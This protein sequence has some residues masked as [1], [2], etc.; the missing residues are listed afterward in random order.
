MADRFLYIP[1]LGFCMVA[2]YCGALILGWRTV[3]R[4]SASY[5]VLT[6]ITCMVILTVVRTFYW[7]N[8]A[9]LWFRTLHTNPM[10]Y[11]AYGSIAQILEHQ[12]KIDDAIAAVKNGLMLKPNDHRLLGSLAIL[13]MRK[14]EYKQALYYFT[15]SLKCE[16]RDYKP[17]ANM[18]I[19]YS[20]MGKVDEAVYS[21]NRAIELNPSNI[22]LHFY[23]AEYCFKQGQ[24]QPALDEY[25]AIL[26]LDPNNIDALTALASLYFD[27]LED[28]QP[29]APLYKRIMELQ[30]DNIEAYKRYITCN[31]K[32]LIQRE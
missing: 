2:G 19:M 20:E 8:S 21:I 14:K 11:R 16:P 18:F 23:K 32:L 10:S 31:D 13:Y 5:A 15:Q 28:Y 9:R 4:R 24:I 6:V 29:A 27:V 7:H 25:A 17:Y 1:S 26:R 12:G 3:Y 22:L 30:P